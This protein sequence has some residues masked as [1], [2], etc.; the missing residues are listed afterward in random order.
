MPRKKSAAS[1]LKGQFS[2][3]HLSDVQFEEYCY[4]LLVA[5][6]Y[7]NVHW[8]KGTG[9]S[10]SP[11]DR[12]RDIE[13]QYPREDADGTTSF[14]TWFVDCKHYIEGVGPDKLQ[15]AIGWATAKRPHT[16]LFIASN[17][18]SN[19]AKDFLAEYEQANNPPFRILYWERPKLEYMSAGRVTL[20]QK[21]RL[22][23]DFPFLDIVH[24][25][26]LTYIRK[27]HINTLRYMFECFDACDD[28]TKR[29][30]I[31]WW[32]R[33]IILGRFY[34][35]KGDTSDGDILVR[36]VA[37]ASHEEFKAACYEIVRSG[38][39]DQ[40]V[41]TTFIVSLSLQ[42]CLEYGDTTA[43]GE[44]AARLNESLELS[45]NFREIYVE[46]FQRR[47]HTEADLES[48]N[49]WMEQH[50]RDLPKEVEE[51]REL[52]V[53]FCEQVV[54]R[55]VDQGNINAEDWVLPQ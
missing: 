18:L 3:N 51:G 48:F 20:R 39:I 6:G 53:Y 38:I 31:L 9:K 55:L 26:H 40:V 15:N 44:H 27:M 14:E 29:D 11:S 46:T 33:Q 34:R 5:L 47:G 52:Y 17:F 43:I 19:G 24:P 41:F 10:S 1:E 49:A 13:C 42:F 12:G 35:V 21:Y 36:R 32:P 25:A 4:D 30:H 8:R 37:K 50:V 22:P 45:R 2:L 54:Q 7:R 23:I 28:A 16:L